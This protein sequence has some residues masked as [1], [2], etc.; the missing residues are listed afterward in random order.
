MR[1]V[2]LFLAIATAFA[3][4]QSQNSGYEAAEVAQPAPAV[5]ASSGG[6][7]QQAYNSD[8]ASGGAGGS[9]PQSMRFLVFLL[10]IGA[11]RAQLSQNSGYEDAEGSQVGPS[12]PPSSDGGDQQAY[13]SEPGA[14]GSGGAYEVGGGSSG[15]GIPRPGSSGGARP[16]SSGGSSGGGASG[17]MTDS[18]KD[19]ERLEKK[20]EKLDEDCDKVV[21]HVAC[22]TLES[23]SLP[24][25]PNM[26]RAVR[27]KKRLV[28]RPRGYKMDVDPQPSSSQSKPDSRMEWDGAES[29]LSSTSESD[30]GNCA[31]DADDEQSDWVGYAPSVTEG[32]FDPIEERRARRLQQKLQMSQLQRRLERFALEGGRGEMGIEFRIKDRPNS[33]QVGKFNRMLLHYRLEVVK[34]QRGTVVIRR[35]SNPCSKVPECD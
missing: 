4:G 8:G 30:G 16:G 1:S 13:N 2:V 34:R 23:D 35:K 15:G 25:T 7:D 11:A 24:E 14:G 29:C 17:L 6:G 28:R 21:T 22:V 20:C 27:K 5:P 18:E 12:E 3:H 10:A 9:A 31:A 33:M 19:K 32:D 26:P